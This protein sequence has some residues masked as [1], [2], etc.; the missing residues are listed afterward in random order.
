MYRPATIATGGWRPHRAFENHP[1]ERRP[2]ATQRERE[3]EEGCRDGQ[4]QPSVLPSDPE[5]R[6]RDREL[7]GRRGSRLRPS[8][9]LLAC[10]QPRPE[11]SKTVGQD[12]QLTRP[13]VNPRL[14]E[15]ERIWTHPRRDTRCL[16]RLALKRPR[17]E[18]AKGQAPA[19]AKPPGF[20]GL[21]GQPAAKGKT[22]GL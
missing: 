8:R 1:V 12:A 6:I 2:R 5:V 3:S 18:S 22:G 15:F 11:A 19:F 20:C 7:D 13:P 16:D 17:T 10:S 21:S 9:T 4:V 14:R